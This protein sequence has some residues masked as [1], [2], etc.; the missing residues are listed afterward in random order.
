MCSPRSKDALGTG[1]TTRSRNRLGLI[2]AASVLKV[3][4]GQAIALRRVDRQVNFPV[5]AV[6]TQ[7]WCATI[8]S[9]KGNLPFMTVAC[10][11][12]ARYVGSHQYPP[13]SA[14][15]DNPAEWLHMT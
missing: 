1:A 15:N 13:A 2:Q 10:R 7:R 5:V 12:R 14:T 9:T 11:N 8:T 4:S 6:G 3:T